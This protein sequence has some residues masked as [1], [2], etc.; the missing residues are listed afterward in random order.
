MRR[1][2]MNYVHFPNSSLISP[3]SSPRYSKLPKK[4]KKKKTPTHRPNVR[5]PPLEH[6]MHALE[7]RPPVVRPLERSQVGAVRVGATD[8]HEDGSDGRT[9][10]QVGGEGGF[11]GSR[12]AG[13]GEGEGASGGSDEGLHGR[14]GVSGLD[15]YRLDWGGSERWR[16]GC[17]CGCR[18]ERRVVVKGG[19]IDYQED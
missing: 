14:K 7:I 4:K 13:V 12:I 1:C 3:P 8:A 6:G 2:R 17:G 11:H 16:G 10:S 18:F 15:V 5:I 19:E 9:V